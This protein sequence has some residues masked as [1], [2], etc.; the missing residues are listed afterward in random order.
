MVAHAPLRAGSCVSKMTSDWNGPRSP[1][2]CG[3]WVV[4]IIFISPSKL[5]DGFIGTKV[6]CVCRSYIASEPLVQPASQQKYRTST[7]NDA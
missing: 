7:N 1:S 5:L 6:D 3:E 4:V 2:T